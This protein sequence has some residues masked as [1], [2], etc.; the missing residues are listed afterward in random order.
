MDELP[1]ENIKRTLISL[2]CHAVSNLG[3]EHHLVAA[4][5]IVHHIIKLRLKCLLVDKIEIN[6]IISSN[7]NSN[8]A[9]DVINE[10]PNFK[11]PKLFPIS[12]SCF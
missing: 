4:V 1:P 9:F 6:F 3:A 5:E 10:T 2:V 11:N 7:L 12:L 8:I